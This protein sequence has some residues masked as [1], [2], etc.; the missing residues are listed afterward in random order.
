LSWKSNDPAV[1]LALDLITAAQGV[2]SAP[3]G[4]FLVAAFSG[5]QQ[6]ILTARRLQWA[7]LGFSE[8]DQFAGTA[9]AVLVHS[10]PDLPGLEADSSVLLPLEN[11]APGQI[12]LTPKTSEL[13][14]DLPGLPLQAAAGDG[15]CELLWRTSEETSSRS[16]DEETLSQFIKLH[17]LENEASAPPQEPAVTPADPLLGGAD[18]DLYTLPDAVEPGAVEFAYPDP[19]LSPSRLRAN[20]RHHYRANLRWTPL[21]P[22]RLRANPRLLIGAACAAVIVLVIVV[23]VAVSHKGAAKS[24]AIAVQPASSTAAPLPSTGQP[25]QSQPANPVPLT[26][27]G[28]PPEPARP[29]TQTQKGRKREEPPQSNPTPSDTAKSQA[30]LPK[31]A[32]GNCD[33]D[34]NLLPKMLDQAERSREQ[35][36]YP[37]ALRQFRAVLACDHNNARARNGLDLTQF[38]MQHR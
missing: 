10:T 25:S 26:G 3:H 9:V 8:A 2:V 19:G 36:N 22:S 14:Q 1:C 28:T 24:A 37:A 32:G 11:A 33:L 16:S 23:I 7:V 4:N 20:P 34:S 18:R 5:I 6:A 30:N 27:T 12:L 21:S 17:G 29:S 13:L 38:D 31:V 15:L 35:G